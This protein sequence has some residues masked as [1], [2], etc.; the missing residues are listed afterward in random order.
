MD[1]NFR[2]T[3]NETYIKRVGRNFMMIDRIFRKMDR[4][5]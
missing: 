4:N 1:R 3:D 2:N 5:F